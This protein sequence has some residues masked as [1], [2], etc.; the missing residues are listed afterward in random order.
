MTTLEQQIGENVRALRGQRSMQALGL[1]LEP[2]TGRAWSRQAVWDAERGHRAFTAAELLALAGA[3]G[4]TLPQLFETSGSIT[5]PSGESLPAS[6]VDAL[7]AGTNRGKDRTLR[8]RR[9]LRGLRAFQGE[10]S[11]LS[12]IL[13]VQVAR[14]ERA[15]SG[16]PAPE[17]E[18]GRP[19]GW[20]L[21]KADE[22]AE[23]WAAGGPKGYTET[24][25]E[26]DQRDE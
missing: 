15:L 24:T 21:H 1:A 26:E 9:E 11:Y 18:T 4:V 19:A 10:L 23:K 17:F 20:M 2:F 8:L 14:L 12:T 6:A 16:A 13:G 5:M 7:L 22:Q 3:L 25:Y